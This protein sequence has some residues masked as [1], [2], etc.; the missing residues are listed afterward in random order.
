MPLKVA[1]RPQL[2]VRADLLER[3]AAAARRSSKG[4]SLLPDDNLRRILD[5]DEEMIRSVLHGLGYRDAGRDGTLQAPGKAS[6]R[7]GR[8]RGPK[9]KD[10]SVRVDSESPFSVLSDLASGKKR[11]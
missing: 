6:R 9:G 5:C 4:G 10:K 1:G 2:A 3:L 7:A 11:G 8:R